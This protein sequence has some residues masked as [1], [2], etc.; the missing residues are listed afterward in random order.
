MDTK[1][2]RVNPL[3]LSGGGSEDA[4]L[5][6]IYGP[7]LGRKVSLPLIG[8]F[9]IGR[10]E[11]NAIVLEMDN[12]SRKHCSF[13]TRADGAWVR[14]EGSTNGTWLNNVEVKT[15]TMLRSGD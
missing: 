4:C 10:G 11:Q 12:V 8:E 13:I 2:T 15:E 1:I 7:Q 6:Q 3:A 9:T 14:D 5:V